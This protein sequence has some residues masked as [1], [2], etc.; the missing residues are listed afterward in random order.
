MRAD[1]PLLTSRGRRTPEPLRV[2]L[3]RRLDLPVQAQLWDQGSAPTLVAHGPQAPA[4]ACDRLDRLAVE[5][6]C[7]WN[8]ANRRPF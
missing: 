8:A 4:E 1:D 7:L 6:G 5:S 3:S 2:V